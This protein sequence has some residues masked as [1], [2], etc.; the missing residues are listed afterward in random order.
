METCP[1]NGFDIEADPP[2]VQDPCIGCT[3]CVMACPTCS[4]EG[5]WSMWTAYNPEHYAMLRVWLD[6]QAA[7]VEFRWLMD[8]DTVDFE[9]YM[10]LRHKRKLMEKKGPSD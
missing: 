8:P 10:F 2:R 3:I 9:D 7:K 6:K 1:V 4:I 5:D